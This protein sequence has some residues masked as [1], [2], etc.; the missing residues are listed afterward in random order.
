MSIERIN[1]TREKNI[2]P[3]ILSLLIGQQGDLIRPKTFSGNY[4]GISEHSISRTLNT[5]HWRPR[6]S[7]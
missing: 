7:S 5:S 1:E 3:R 2:L 6:T 4:A